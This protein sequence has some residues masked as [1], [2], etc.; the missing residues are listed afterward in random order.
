MAWLQTERL[1][2]LGFAR[3]AAHTAG[4]DDWDGQCRSDQDQSPGRDGKACR[5]MVTG[6][7]KHGV[8]YGH[9]DFGVRARLV[10]DSLNQIVGDDSLGL[11]FEVEQDT[12]AQRGKS[13]GGYIL[14][15]NV[16]ATLQQGT[17]LG[18]QNDG[19]RPARAG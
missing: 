4:E 19:L 13:D 9:F 15:G 16:V 12:M 2:N 17:N 11:A 18:R 7:R 1:Q 6:I 3:N 10:Q 8:L 5:A 14:N